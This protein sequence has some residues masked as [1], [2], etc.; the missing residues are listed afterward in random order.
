MSQ[1]ATLPVDKA[2][3][4]G[5]DAF[6]RA[7]LRPDHARI[8]TGILVRTSLRGVDTHGFARIPTYIDGL[9]DGTLRAQPRLDCTMV[10]GVA[11]YDGGK[12]IGQAIGAIATEAAIERA[13]EVPLALSLIRRSG[14]LGALG[15]Y[16][17]MA[18][19]AGMV[20]MVG[21]ATTPLI[22]LPGF[23]GRAVGNNPF[24]FA[25]PVPDGDPV[26]FDA[27]MSRISRSKLREMIRD[28]EPIPEG[29]AIDPDGNPTTD[30]KAAWE[31][32][33][34]P[35][36]DYKGIG[37]AL[38]IQVLAGSMTGSAP[39]LLGGGDPLANLSA[40]ILVINPALAGSTGFE[41]DM[42]AW[43]SHYG[44]AAGDGRYPGQRGAQLERERRQGGI[45]LSAVARAELAK[46]ASKLGIEPVLPQ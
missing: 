3:Q 22:G 38:L 39:D 40:F 5:A 41:A 13:R 24:A 36:G 7:G 10:N 9:L 35:T 33:M 15:I 31:G 27:A 16:A 8:A 26:V 4:W 28:G 6:T 1:P 14:H 45:P 42:A 29:V 20:A 21:Q 46:A 19:E 12:G 18:A 37:F 2:L 34:L 11:H 25:A 30:P 17:L 32:A 23:R 43:F 44:K